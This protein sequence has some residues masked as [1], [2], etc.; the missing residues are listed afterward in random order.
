[1]W[2]ALLLFP[3]ADLTGLSAVATVV[4]PAARLTVHAD[5][6]VHTD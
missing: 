6:G 2:V 3:L 5:A 1:M 4:H